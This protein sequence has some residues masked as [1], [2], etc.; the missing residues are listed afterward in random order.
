MSCVV[1]G[2]VAIISLLWRWHDLAYNFL[3][4]CNF[5]TRICQ[6][7]FFR[8][9]PSQ[10]RVVC[11]CSTT[12]KLETCLVTVLVFVYRC[13]VH[14]PPSTPGCDTSLATLHLTRIHTKRLL[15]RLTAVAVECCHVARSVGQLPLQTSTGDGPTTPAVLGETRRV[16]VVDTSA[17]GA[18]EGTVS[19]LT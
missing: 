10:G 3:S 12:W 19:G 13:S 1:P 9:R 11:T 17:G 15:V 4:F 14:H 16:T 2:F 5:S 18:R 6:G 7:L 8:A